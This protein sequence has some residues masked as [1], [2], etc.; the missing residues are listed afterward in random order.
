MKLNVMLGISAVV[1]TLHGIIALL[2]PATLMYGTLADGASAGLLA[3]LRAPASLALGFAVLNWVARNA[4]PSKARNAIV[5]ANIV[6]LV[7]LPVLEVLAVLSG[8]RT[9]ELGPA[10]VSLLLA[11]GFVWAGRTSSPKA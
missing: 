7:L 1:W 10:F 6:A 2:S 9:F 4:E 3:N 5:I 8:A 11:A